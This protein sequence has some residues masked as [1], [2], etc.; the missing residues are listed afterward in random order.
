MKTMLV[1]TWQRQ[2][3]LYARAAPMPLFR[4]KRESPPPPKRRISEVVDLD[5]TSFDVTPPSFEFE[6]F[7]RVLL[8]YSQWTSGEQ[9]ARIVRIAV[10]VI[11]AN[12]SVRIV[13]MAESYDTSIVVTVKKEEAEMYALRLMGAGLKSSTEEA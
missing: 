2:P 4:R 10:P 3:Q 13:S 1:K 11:T 12:E 8:H 7:Y 6:P 5:A 9:V